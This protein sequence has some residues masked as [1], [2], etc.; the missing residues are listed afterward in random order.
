MPRSPA[1]V[2]TL[3]AP[4]TQTA[5][6]SFA[7]HALSCLLNIKAYKTY[8]AGKV[9]GAALANASVD[10]LSLLLIC[11]DGCDQ[12]T[13]VVASPWGMMTQIARAPPREIGCYGARDAPFI[14]SDSVC[15]PL[16]SIAT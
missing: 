14:R 15:A 16:F 8:H 6:R 7:A 13:P 12:E 5:A 10:R 2:S 4:A 11:V 3:A 9:S 1:A